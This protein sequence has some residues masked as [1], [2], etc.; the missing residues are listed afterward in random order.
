[1]AL[2]ETLADGV[3]TI[4]MDNPPVNAL[5]IADTYGLATI[6]DGYRTRG[7]VRAVVLTAEGRGFCAGVDIKEIQATDADGGH[8]G[9]VEAN[10]SCAEAF[11]AVYECAVPVVAAVN[12][13]C[14]GT[15]I[16][17]VGNADVIV[18]AEGAGFGLPE[19]DN[20]ALGA[21]THLMRLVPAHRARWMLYSCEP[22][23]AEELHGYGS[24][25]RVVAADDLA[26][27]AALVAATIA[28]KDGAVMRA[29]KASMNGIDPVDVRTSYRFEQGFTFE[30]NLLGRGDEARAAFLRGERDPNAAAD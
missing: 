16:G 23:T 6:L 11:R 22:A 13:F 9:L 30:L 3:A 15:G 26:D 8:L 5:G 12:G 25:L 4:T 20:G 18:A 19:V 10:R 27:T 2:H 14:L 7:D 24:V 21:A 28:A 17:L 29:A 1:M